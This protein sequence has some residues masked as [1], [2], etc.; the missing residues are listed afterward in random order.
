MEGISR[1]MVKICPASLKNIVEKVL[2]C[3]HAIKYI[4]NTN[5]ELHSCVA[6]SIS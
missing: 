4:L 5:N 2:N 6:S 3:E 1:R